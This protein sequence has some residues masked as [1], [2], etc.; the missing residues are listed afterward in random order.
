MGLNGICGK[1]A[2]RDAEATS[3]AGTSA[4]TERREQTENEKACQQAL[5][6]G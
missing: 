1:T 6:L 2:M 4:A 3:A 5:T